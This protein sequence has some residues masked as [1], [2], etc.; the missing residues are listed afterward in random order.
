MRRASAAFSLAMVVAQV[1][2]VFFAISIANGGALL[3]IH[4]AP[5]A[6]S[7]VYVI[8][9]FRIKDDVHRWWLNGVFV[10]L[11]FF[12]FN[13]QG[14]LIDITQLMSCADELCISSE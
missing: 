8:A 1:P 12:I 2:L 9:I 7:L 4:T 5:A 13:F 11:V 10:V 14:Q 3:S 6:I